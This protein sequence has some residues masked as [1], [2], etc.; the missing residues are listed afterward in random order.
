MSKRVLPG[1]KPFNELNLKSCYY[2]QVVAGYSLFGIDPKIIAGN[3]LPLYKFDEKEKVL[4]VEHEEIFTQ[5]ELY[6][7]TG[8]E[9]E[10]FKP[11]KNLKEFVI[12]Q[13]DNGCPVI[14]P[15]DCFYLTY[16]ED[17]YK[18]A[19]VSHFIL[20]YGYDLEQNKFYINE[21]HF[22]NS[23]NYRERIESID[24]LNRGYK[25]FLDG[26]IKQE[27]EEIILVLSKK[28]NGKG[29]YRE[30][31]RNSLKMREE[32]L[33]KSKKN[34]IGCINFIQ[35]CLYS[36]EKR[37]EFQEQIID[38]FGKIRWYKN[39]QRNILALVFESESLKEIF[40]RIYENY[41]FI[42]GMFVKIKIIG[43][44]QGKNT[45]KLVDRLDELKLLEVSAHDLLSKA[46]RL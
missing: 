35:S 14:I 24:I 16:R 34:F 19:H 41:V 37:E 3:Y 30:Y 5:K 31:Y 13:I 22:L 26:L 28:K 21:H 32:A 39:V 44:S 20:I 7:L 29:D 43:Q 17:L 18:K 45:K 10:F 25:H 6:D 12:T 4:D 38:F 46:D 42:Y 40:D 2:N 23:P 36:D 1:L 15:V 11:V 8:V 33:Q 27:N 9:K